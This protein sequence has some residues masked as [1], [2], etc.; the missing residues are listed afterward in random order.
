MIFWETLRLAFSALG[1]NKLRS[2]LTMFGIAVGVFSVI[3]V[4]TVVSG[5]NDKVVSGLNV[6]GANS[7][8]IMKY[9][10][11]NFS[12]PRSRF[13]NRPDIS[14]AQAV[15]FKELMGD[16]AEV[17]VQLE[18]PWRRVS[19]L[20]RRTNPNVSILGGDENLAT[21]F[22]L[23]FAA[24][25][26]LGADDVAFGRAVAILGDNVVKI[27]FP[28]EDPIGQAVRI[29]GQNFTVIGQLAF[30]GNSFGA[31][32]DN[33]VIIP[34]TQFLNSYG[35]ARRSMMLNVKAPNAAAVEATQDRAI[36][37]MRLVRGLDAED[38]DDFELATNDT[39]IAMFRTIGDKIAIGAFIISAIAL[40]AA[41]VGV[42]N[43]MLVSVTER[44]KEI[45][46]RKS[47]GAKKQNI[48][49]QFLIEAVTIS[50][51]GGLVGIFSGV[52]I[53]NIIFLMLGA[54]PVF[55]WF[56]ALAA[57]AVCCGIGVG[58]GI[59]PAW[60]AA[61]LDPIEALRFE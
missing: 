61:A 56:W 6:L 54:S 18:R 50:M 51:F 45:G 15:R 37:V 22:N 49:V 1:A 4:M 10:I 34:V 42:M 59:Y 27:L 16:S 31:S 12:D 36:G 47:V 9:P 60:R 39:L 44:T 32:N 55:P 58:F 48:L 29:D 14:Y 43:I 26:N 20:D 13:A 57:V 30:K 53:G 33:R 19:H 35:R 23:D 3:G 5:L 28:N 46:I 24:G 7:I 8:Q 40:V 38:P 52:I 41:G 17:S 25:R 21:A 2:A 11:I